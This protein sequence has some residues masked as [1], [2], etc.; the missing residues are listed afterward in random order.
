MVA[1]PCLRLA[2]AAAWKGRPHHPTTGAVRASAAQCRCWNCS[3]GIIAA[4]IT[5]PARAMAVTRRLRSEASS[6]SS[7]GGDGFATAA[8]YPAFS[9]SVISVCGS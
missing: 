8:A 6:R 7:C 4:A 3:A 9:I 5:G 2:H 1:T